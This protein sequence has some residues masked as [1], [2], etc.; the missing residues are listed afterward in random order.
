ML[1]RLSSVLLVYNKPFS[2]DGYAIEFTAS[3]EFLQKMYDTDPMLEEIDFE[4]H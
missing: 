2:F 4:V 3:E 1:C